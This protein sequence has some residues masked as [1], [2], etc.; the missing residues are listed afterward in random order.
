MVRIGKLKMNLNKEKQKAKQQL[1]RSNIILKKQENLLKKHEK[2]LQGHNKQRKK[3]D[4][5]IKENKIKI[6]KMKKTSMWVGLILGLAI[7]EIK[8]RSIRTNEL[9]KRCKA[10]A[11]Q[12]SILK[13][14][15]KKE[16]LELTDE[17]KKESNKLLRELHLK[18]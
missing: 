2:I 7:L 9:L 11:I 18:I 17:E 16:L 12:V 15:V 14:L 1:N 5:E 3:L 8:E 13:P 6:R 10:C 4:K